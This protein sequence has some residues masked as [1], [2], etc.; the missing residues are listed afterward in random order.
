MVEARLRPA[1]AFRMVYPAACVSFLG[2]AGRGHFDVGAETADYLALFIEKSLERRLLPDGGLVPVDPADGV[3]AASWLPDGD[4]RRPAP[5]R[6]DDYTGCRHEAFWYF[7]AEMAALAEAR[8]AATDGKKPC[9]IAFTDTAGSLLPYNARAHCRQSMELRADAQGR[10]G[11]AAVFTDSTRTVRSACRPD[12]A[13]SVHYVS[14]PARELAPGLFE[15]AAD[16]PSWRNPKRRGRVT[17]CA[18]APADS[19]YKGCVQE[20]EIVLR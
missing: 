9:H 13:I 16:H 1:L 20:I 7:D 6:P 14:G 5:A 3:L 12:S 15:V 8:Y 2:D 17:L 19:V 4:A 10:F 11:A 18:E